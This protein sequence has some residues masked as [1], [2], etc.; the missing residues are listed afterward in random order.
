MLLEED[1]DASL[2]QDQEMYMKDRTVVVKDHS[3]PNTGSAETG[4][5]PSKEEVSGNQQDNALEEAESSLVDM[6]RF[7]LEN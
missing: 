5:L 6:L 7:E 2:S 4:K 3:M 1:S